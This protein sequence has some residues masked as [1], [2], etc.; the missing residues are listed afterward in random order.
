MIKGCIFDVIGDKNYDKID[1][2]QLT[3]FIHHLYSTDENEKYFTAANIL[4]IR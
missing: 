3:I 1:L 4:S 2:V